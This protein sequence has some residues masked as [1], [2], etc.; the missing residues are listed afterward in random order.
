MRYRLRTLLGLLTLVACL[1]GVI[2]PMLRPSV[3]VRPNLFDAGNLIGGT[4][5]TSVFN[6][7]NR[8][9]RPVQLRRVATVGRA[10]SD[11]DDLTIPAG[12]SRQIQ[13]SWQYPPT[14]SDPSNSETIAHIR[15]E[16]SDR[17]RPWIDLTTVGR[18]VAPSSAAQARRAPAN[19]SPSR[20]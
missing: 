5:G 20:N 10:N 6:V 14:Q 13:V 9:L 2:V 15:F 1:V 8:G 17:R 11:V 16:S 7:S 4:H 3:H 18:V 12:E 19:M